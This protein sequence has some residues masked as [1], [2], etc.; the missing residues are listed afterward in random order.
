MKKDVPLMNFGL[1]QNCYRL[2]SV[3]SRSYVSSGFSVQ[4][5]YPEIV[6]S[7]I[8][9]GI[10]EN[11]VMKPYPHTV[12]AINS[13]V[14][15]SDYRLDPALAVRNG[16][17]LPNLGDVRSIQAASKL[18][19]EDLLKMRSVLDSVLA[20]LKVSAPSESV[21]SVESASVESVK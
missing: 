20:K 8:S 12:E 13:Y 6:E 3:S 2:D 1:K 9:N 15:V 4:E 19:T 7:S 16:H 10:R 11:I 18:S 17:S 14:D 21:E 5:E